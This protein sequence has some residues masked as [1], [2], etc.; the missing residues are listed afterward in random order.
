[1]GKQTV[2]I[3]LLTTYIFPLSLLLFFGLNSNFFLNPENDLLLGYFVFSVTLILV[4]FS[5]FVKTKPPKISLENININHAKHLLFFLASVFCFSAFYSS[6]VYETS[7]RHT[8]SLSDALFLT[9]IYFSLKAFIPLILLIFLVNI[10]NRNKISNY[11]KLSCFL[12]FIGLIS[13]NTSGFDGFYALFF[14]SIAVIGSKNI[15]LFK[16]SSLQTSP[17]LILLPI[18]IVLSAFSNRGNMLIGDNF[19]D[20]V[21]FLFNQFDVFSYLGY[22]LTIF[23]SSTIINFSNPDF[24]MIWYEGLSITIE[25]F[26]RNILVL[27]G[28]EYER[29]LLPNINVLNKNLIAFNHGGLFFAKEGTSPGLLASFFFIL[30]FPLAIF[31]L[32]IYVNFISN[33]LD[34]LFKGNNNI[35]LSV[36][37]I[38]I[39]FGILNSPAFVFT[40]LVPSL[41]TS[42]GLIMV[43]IFDFNSIKK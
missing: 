13:F 16:L 10:C 19:F 27:L 31:S 39:F 28:M 38:I 34:R 7:F 29:D 35:L 23:I 42:I 43:L 11:S 2:L 33:S 17:I 26:Y 25:S 8:E 4:I 24:Y 15:Y 41:I 1:M 40:S 12:L 37:V 30:P 3:Y 32:C 22:R 14:L 9:K 18:I 21:T 6:T 5:A 20:S 36:S